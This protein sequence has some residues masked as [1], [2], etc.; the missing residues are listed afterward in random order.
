MAT[1]Q[2][3][4]AEQKK[5]IEFLASKYEKDTGRKLNLPSSLGDML[6]DDSIV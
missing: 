4:L 3:K 1:L 2:A 6:G 5:I